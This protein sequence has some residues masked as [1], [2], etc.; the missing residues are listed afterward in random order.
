MIYFLTIKKIDYFI[1][2]LNCLIIN[3]QSPNH[4][5]PVLVSK[6]VSSMMVIFKQFC[7]SAGNPDINDIT[8]SIIIGLHIIGSVTT[9]HRDKFIRGTLN[10]Y[11]VNS[12][13]AQLL[14]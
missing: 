3:N 12:A 6:S 1:V 11:D 10:W 14:M 8:K 4:Q 13:R 2:I 7:D 5:M 9:E